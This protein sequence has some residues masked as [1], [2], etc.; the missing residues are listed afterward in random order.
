MNGVLVDSYYVDSQGN[1]ILDDQGKELSKN[2]T[3][4][5]S[6]PAHIRSQL[7]APENAGVL[8]S[9]RGDNNDPSGITASNI[10]ISAKW[11]SGDVKIVNSYEV[12]PNTNPPEVGTTDNTN[13]LHMVTLMN[14]DLDYAPNELIANANKDTMFTG[15]FGE[16][17]GNINSV[18][19]NDQNSTQIMLDNYYMS[20]VELDTSRDAVSSV[21][22]N[23]ETVNMIQYQKSYSAACRL[24]TTMDEILDKLINGTGIAGR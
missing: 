10:S 7:V 4:I 5:D 21:D 22:L 12:I 13:I 16:M 9:N 8:F 17:L 18:L 24:M 11:A 15:S 19:G 14:K 6:L 23:D 1:Y 2:T 20:A 3:A